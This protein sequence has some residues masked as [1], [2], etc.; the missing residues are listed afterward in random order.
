MAHLQR[1]TRQT[2]PNPGIAQWHLVHALGY[3]ILCAFL[4]A[5]HLPAQGES[6]K[7]PPDCKDPTGKF[8]LGPLGA[9]L[10]QKTGTPWGPGSS[11][12]APHSHN[13][14]YMGD[15]STVDDNGFVDVTLGPVGYT[16]NT[17]EKWPNPHTGGDCIPPTSGGGGGGSSGPGNDP[18]HDEKPGP[19]SPIQGISHSVPPTPAGEV[20]SDCS[21][22]NSN[23]KCIVTE[24]AACGAKSCD[25]S[26]PSTSGSKVG[27]GGP[28]LTEYFGLTSPSGGYHAGITGVPGS[29]SFFYREHDAS[30]Q[31]AFVEV[32][33]VDGTITRYQR[34]ATLA[35][36]ER[37]RPIEHVDAYDNI[38]RYVYIQGRLERIQHPSGIDEVWNYSPDWIGT[39]PGDWSSA[40]YS[41]I[42]VS[43]E[44][45]SG[46]DPDLSEKTYY[47]LFKRLYVNGQ[48]EILSRPL[49]GDRLY[50][51][52]HPKGRRLDDLPTG[53]LLHTLPAGML[54]PER[55]SVIELVYPN[56]S[57]RVARIEHLLADSPYQNAT[58]TPSIAVVEYTYNLVGGVHRVSQEKF[59][60]S[61]LIYNFV[62]T[63]DALP[64]HDG[65]LDAIVRTD[66]LGGRVTKVLDDFHRPTQV[67]VEPPAGVAGRPRATDPDNGGW[68][69]PPMLT[70]N[71]QYASCSG[72]G[73]RPSVIEEL[74]SGR[75]TECDYDAV[76]GLL[77]RERT[78]NPAGGSSLV[79]TQY[80]W[81]PNVAGDIYGAYKLTATITPDGQVWNYTYQSTGRNTPAGRASWGVKHS[82][83]T[84]TSPNVSLAD[85]SQAVLT[86]DWHYNV[87]TPPTSGG[88]QV[89]IVGQLWKAVD[90]DGVATEFDF[91]GAGLLTTETVNKGGG[92]SELVTSFLCDRWGIVQQVTQNAGSSLPLV[93]TYASDGSGY[94]TS[95]STTIGAQVEETRVLYDRWGNLTVQLRRNQNAAG[96]APNDFGTN[97]R[98]DQARDWLR[99][100]WH[101][102]GG[103]LVTRLR[104]RRTLDRNDVGA[105]ADALD[106]RFWREDYV[107]L[108]H[109]L[110]GAI[111]H[112]NGSQT[113]LTYDGYG[114]LYKAERVGSGEPTLLLG[115]W[116]VNSAL[117]V[118]REFRGGGGLALATTIGR[119]A[120]GF[121]TSV[122]EP[123][124]SAP[125]G[126]PW[127]LENST[128]Y[129][130]HDVMGQLVES[131]TTGGAAVL[132]RSKSYF[133]Q[134][135][136]PWKLERFDGAGTAAIQ[137]LT[138]LWQGASK[139]KKSTDPA[140]RV[141]ERAFDALA[142]V[143]E[144]K[145]STAANADKVT[146][147]F[148]PKTSLARFRK[149]HLWDPTLNVPGY[150]I[151]QTE[152]V[153]DNAG[154]V[155]QAKVGPS[156]A[157][158]VHS[159]TY[160]SA[161][162][163]ETY[164]DP[165]GKVEKY[166]PDA[167]GRLGER[168]LPGV[169]PIWNESK[170]LDWTGSKDR[171]I[172]E[173]RDGRDR[174]TR[175]V[176]DFAGR[177]VVVMEPGAGT[178]PSEVAKHQPY[179]RFMEYDAA[180]RLAYV[181]AG[182][183]VRVRFDRDG[184]GQLLLRTR[185]TAAGHPLVSWAYGRDELRWN[186]LGQLTEALSRTGFGPGGIGDTYVHEH[187]QHDGVS[188]LL[189]E[190]FTFAGAGNAI[191]IESAFTAGDWFRSAVSYRNNLGG[192]LNDLWM[193][194]S[195]DSVG[196]VQALDWKTS[197]GAAW[198]PLANYVHEGTAT[199]K[200]TT[201]RGLG[202]IA[203]FGSFD[204][205]YSYDAYG[206]MVGIQQSFDVN[207][208]VSFTYDLASN[209]VEEEYVKQGG[210]NRRG[211]RFAYDEHHRL[212]KAWLGSNQAHLD[213][214]DPESGV[215]T[216]VKKLTYG[217]DAA[218]SRAS[219]QTQLGPS[220]TVSTSTYSTDDDSQ[221]SNRYDLV[222]GVEPA[223]DARGNTVFDGRFYYI[224]DALNRLTEVYRIEYSGDDESFVLSDPS[225]LR[226]ARDNIASRVST[227]PENVLLRIADPT[228]EPQLKDPVSASAL[229]PAQM[230]AGSTEGTYQLVL[231]AVYLYDVMNRRVV[232]AVTGQGDYYYAWD[233]W[234][235]AQELVKTG[236]PA[237]AQPRTQFAWG[238]RLDELISYR[239]NQS[240]AWSTYYVAEGGAHCPSRVLNSSGTV[241]EVQE[242][243][244]YG[245]T[246]FWTGVSPA[247]SSAHG[248]P[249]GWKGLRI[250]PETGLVYM[251]NRYYTPVWGR[252][253]TQD[254]LGTWA[255]A[256][257]M[258]NAYDYVGANPGTHDDPYG[259]Q[260]FLGGVHIPDPREVEAARKQAEQR[261]AQEKA[262]AEAAARAESREFWAAVAA[263]GRDGFLDSRFPGRRVKAPITGGKKA[264]PC[265][266]DGKKTSSSPTI[267]DN[268]KKG[269][270]F[271]KE[272]AEELK[273]KEDVVG[274][275]IT[276]ETPEGTRTRM[277]AIGKTGD[278]YKLEEYKSSDTAKMTKNQEK[279]HPE[280]E[281]GGA[282]VVGEGKPGI[283]GG[284]K[285]PP[286]PVDVV[287]PS[288]GQEK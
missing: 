176:R 269:K 75:R 43:F 104:D 193:Q 44:D 181:N 284:T 27:V 47:M 276:L 76:S 67:V 21:D 134:L 260:T 143:I 54:A 103:R 51:V 94:L 268:A 46:A 236:S 142:R 138:T 271:A 146:Y 204:T 227:S 36:R 49:G 140:G 151:R 85:G 212:R 56:N 48:L 90:G 241:V 158:L 282:T 226:L 195:P 102:D 42:Q 20:G 10:N 221:S 92:N 62:Y 34:Y 125:S 278:K 149:S 124:V 117:E 66:S 111:A 207:A 208:V 93:T 244:P 231:T 107:W 30:G 16:T 200:R 287:R 224:Y 249:F 242:Y 174:L 29:G 155:V 145:N 126:Y 60:L 202:Q 187:F 84:V 8:I 147:E 105:V 53:A 141:V 150:V 116:F 128:H 109:G 97:N 168:Y 237:L 259:L 108:P 38:T 211:D 68:S 110:I 178:E 225:A 246:T 41:G 192:S 252:F 169:A 254:P 77:L 251:R 122:Q 286:T 79:Q 228:F 80:V 17:N 24:C 219:V 78:N 250:D 32:R 238:E 131:W 22:P 189:E 13:G 270:D 69:E 215:G 198:T 165:S 101:Y 19:T 216:F 39:D 213:E 186:G 65:W 262:D 144:V 135:G 162:Y 129:F 184:S 253:L 37:F 45:P 132:A 163:T 261:K 166:L 223:Y 154:R 152:Y 63:P 33:S 273:K 50:R 171:T 255:D 137:T 81:T 257:C 148:F 159:F 173:Q 182:D 89:G 205:T 248:N 139:A 120:A 263:G 190:K 175:T 167:L 100:E 156:T 280:I 133:D 281:K 123:G 283:P 57:D 86:M 230:S 240:G 61:G 239:V 209:L 5:W 274:E 40:T 267:T 55:H 3:L 210:P 153:R 26:Y 9:T 136:R 7:K 130:T 179:A 74:P 222:D 28:K 170:Y 87:N 11:V 112:N 58:T 218:N 83:V 185:V 188:R 232:R 265:P 196:R 18:K 82:R 73:D 118:V 199:R 201:T 288:P 220:G 235:E 214:P 72:C 234:Q 206:R 14:Y 91:N 243:D 6:G 59:P 113:N 23:D 64:G 233:G 164:T 172:L 258:G 99:D 98:T 4:L 106:A 96:G 35:G 119:N 71:Y 160:Y 245:G 161:G 247:D 127:T 272:K 1:P 88:R 217:L 285:I 264:D 177:T 279:A 203:P 277:D 229:E 157:P 275:E 31:T 197:A 194:I 191:E 180:S 256:F 183:D 70:Y 95:V 115:K 121:V 25:C 266:D 52:Y 2:D 114:T 15:E 12:S